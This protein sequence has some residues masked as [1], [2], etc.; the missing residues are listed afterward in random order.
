MI[1]LNYRSNCPRSIMIE[2]QI[3]PELEGK[4][5]TEAV[6]EKYYEGNYSWHGEEI[7]GL[8]EIIGEK[9]IFADSSFLLTKNG[10]LIFYAVMEG[11][12]RY[13]RKDETVVLSKTKKAVSHAYHMRLEL[14]DGSCFGLNLYGWGTSLKIYDVDVGQI[15]TRYHSRNMRYPF[16]PKSPIDVTDPDDFTLEKLQAWLSDKPN[17]NIIEACVTSNGA[18][19]VAIPVMNYIL[20]LSKVHP[21]TKV[22]VLTLADIR[23]IYDNTRKIISD[24]QSGKRICKHID[25]FGKTVKAQNDILWMTSAVLNNPCPVCGS[26]IEA[27]PAAGTKMYFCPIC[28]VIKK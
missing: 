17:A 6:W 14:G 23:A 4:T 28:Q 21:R 18:F 22:R 9:I 16:L 5:I 27:T 10:K 13:F 1:D 8:A 11:D 20:L 15:D 2:R 12:I 24:Y 3:K 25:I 26:S 7:F 19:G